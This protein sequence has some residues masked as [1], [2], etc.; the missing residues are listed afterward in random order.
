MLK[1]NFVYCSYKYV[2]TSPITIRTVSEAFSRWRTYDFYRIG[3]R[4]LFVS[5]IYYTK[6]FYLVQPHIDI[7]NV[8]EIDRAAWEAF[9]EII[10]RK[11]LYPVYS[12]KTGFHLFGKYL[13]K[14]TGA[15][16]H[17]NVLKRVFRDFS[18]ED[19]AKLIG[20]TADM[21][22]STTRQPNPRIGYRADT[23]RFVVPLFTDDLLLYEAVETVRYGSPEKVSE[24]MK[25]YVDFEQYLHVLCPLY[26]VID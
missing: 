24:L 5:P 3:G 20:G 14:M 10:K 21:S 12:G 9:V 11:N 7:N 16:S 2:L 19:I 15:Y 6:Q 8:K 25:R 22:L 23:K 13:V 4:C 17:A 18:P 1:S 26:R